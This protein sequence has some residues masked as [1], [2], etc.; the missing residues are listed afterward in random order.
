MDSMG[1]VCIGTALRVLAHVVDPPVVVATTDV[2]PDE[3]GCV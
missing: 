2:L 3:S 1:G